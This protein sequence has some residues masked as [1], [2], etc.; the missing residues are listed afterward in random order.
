MDEEVLMAASAAHEVPKRAIVERERVP[1]DD[2]DRVVQ[3]AFL[4]LIGAAVVLAG[5][6]VALVTL[7]R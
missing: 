7:L 3:R 1:A 2:F 6:I 5:G 4:L